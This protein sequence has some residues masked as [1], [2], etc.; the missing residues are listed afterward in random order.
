MTNLTDLADRCQVALNDALG[1]TWPDAS[2]LAMLRDAIR[3]YSIHFPRSVKTTITTVASQHSYDLTRLARQVTQVEYPT[4]EDPPRYLD[5]LSRKNPRFWGSDGYY[6]V[7][8]TGDD[9]TGNPSQIWISASPAAG[10]TIT[11]WYTTPHDPIPGLVENNLTV[12][13][14]HEAVLI[15]YVIWQASIDRLATEEQSPDTTIRMMQQYK[16][17]VQAA[18][19]SYNKAIAEAKAARSD[20]GY[21]GPWRSD[22]YDPIY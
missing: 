11:Y 10:E 4:G 3:D 18:E 13:L 6:D 7:E 20:G 14:E 22:T 21:T 15:K 8:F 19:A 2:V 12:P 17:T 16:L 9:N 1:A 5:R